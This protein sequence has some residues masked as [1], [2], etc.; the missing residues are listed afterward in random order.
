MPPGAFSGT[1]RFLLTVSVRLMITE[2]LETLKLGTGKH[3]RVEPV[4]SFP[5]SGRILEGLAHIQQRGG[6]IE[7]AP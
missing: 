3:R 5:V 6:R 1:W 7:M 2:G 4:P